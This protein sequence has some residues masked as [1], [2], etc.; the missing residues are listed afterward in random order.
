MSDTVETLSDLPTASLADLLALPREKLLAW[1]QELETLRLQ[2]RAF[3][4]Q[5]FCTP[6]TLVHEGTHG[7]L[8]HYPSDASS[9]RPVLLIYAWFNRPSVLDLSPRHSFVRALLEQK[10]NVF[11]LA[12][13]D[14][15]HAATADLNDYLEGDLIG[16]VDYLYRQHEEAFDVLGM[17]Q[18]GFSL[19]G[20]RTTYLKKFES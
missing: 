12:W 16:A 6:R 17:C 8:F 10:R 1:Q 3:E 14:P 5:P 19:S 13:K 15:P 11:L 9:Q 20:Q 7:R 18:G 4:Q 2:L